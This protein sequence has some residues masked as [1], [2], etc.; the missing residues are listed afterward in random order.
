MHKLHT[1]CAKREAQVASQFVC[2]WLLRRVYAREIGTFG[3]VCELFQPQHAPNLCDCGFRKLSLPLGQPCAFGVKPHGA[4]LFWGE[5]FQS[6]AHKREL[7]EIPPIADLA[8]GAFHAEILPPSSR[9][10]PQGREQRKC[11]PRF[12]QRAG[13]ASAGVG[14]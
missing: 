11:L 3:T 9:N 5:L 12:G 14:Y 8:A 6:R 13:V 1:M 4:F 7:H 2:I 10:L